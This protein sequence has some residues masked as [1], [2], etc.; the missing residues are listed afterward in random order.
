MCSSDLE[1]ILKL[2]KSARLGVYVAYIYYRS[3]FN[4]I[5]GT[6]AKEIMQQRIRIPNPQKIV[7]FAGSYVRNSLNLL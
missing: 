3:L 1:G 2:P 5:R 7:L 4:K 6:Q